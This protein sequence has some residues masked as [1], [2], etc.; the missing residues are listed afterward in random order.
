MFDRKLN[1]LYGEP[2]MKFVVCMLFHALEQQKLLPLGR[3]YHPNVAGFAVFAQQMLAFAN[4]RKLYPALPWLTVLILQLFPGAS[5]P[6]LISMLTRVFGA[7]RGS[8]EC[9]CEWESD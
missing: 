7:M 2:I 1:P 5:H 8:A 4:C 9:E 3:A 6:P